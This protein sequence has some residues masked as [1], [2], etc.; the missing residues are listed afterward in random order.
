MNDHPNPYPN[1][2]KTA[3][4]KSTQPETHKLQQVSYHQANIRMH[5][6]R[7]LQLDDNKLLTDLLQ[8]ASLFYQLAASLQISSCSKFDVHRLDAT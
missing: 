2:N 6:H 8:V 4:P 5:L 3:R 1:L 7:L